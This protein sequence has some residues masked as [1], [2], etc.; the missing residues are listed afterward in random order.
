MWMK[1]SNEFQWI[2]KNSGWFSGKQ[3][4]MMK[5]I[6]WGSNENEPNPKLLQGS[7]GVVI[8]GLGEKTP[9]CPT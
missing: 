1:F 8:G 2:Q 5:Q 7:R 9:L 4:C 3:L 6:P